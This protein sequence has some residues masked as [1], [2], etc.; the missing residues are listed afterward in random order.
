MSYSK[1][2]NYLK[3]KKL[4]KASCATC[5]RAFASPQWVVASQVSNSNFNVSSEVTMLYE[6]QRPP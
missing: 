5:Y 2:H 1:S 4:S 3:K 6:L